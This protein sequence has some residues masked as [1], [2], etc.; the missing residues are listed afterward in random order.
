MNFLKGLISRNKNRLEK[1]NISLDLSY[2][3]HRII[4]M[5]F[6]S[7]SLVESMYHNNIDEVAYY[8][9]ST[10][11]NNY[12]VFNLSGIPYDITKFNSNVITYQWCDHEAPPLFQILEVCEKAVEFLS[13][14]QKNVVDF[15]CLAGKGRTGTV[16]CC[17]LLFCKAATS[18]QDA[19]DYFAIKRFGG[20][21]KGVRQPSQVRY[22]SFFNYLMN[23]KI[24]F[25]P[26]RITGIFISGITIEGLKTT[27][28]SGFKNGI[29]VDYSP[30]SHKGYIA[31]NDVVI[32]IYE[33]KD[34]GILG[35]SKG[36]SHLCWI[37]FHTSLL[38]LLKNQSSGNNKGNLYFGIN[39]NDPSSLAKGDR[40]QKMVVRVEYE[41]YYYDINEDTE[42]LRSTF[43][44]EQNK[45]DKINQKVDQVNKW[46][47]VENINGEA[48]CLFGTMKNDIKKTIC[49]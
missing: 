41:N 30:F 7:N 28:K 38:F 1:D 22:V 23:N 49:Q 6:P 21:G 40:Y 2:I 4:G 25:H 3:T 17:L 45:V 8:L 13:K 39:D 18:P 26:I 24:A 9:N 44:L 48:K 46:N 14:D 37:C 47:Q 34:Y 15:H 27:I 12:L 43:E 11:L 35:K 42:D 29:E 33:R 10:Y 5:S 16:I 36:M 19:I 31:Y 32:Y 20:I